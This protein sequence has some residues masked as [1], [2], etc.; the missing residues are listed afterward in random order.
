M[1][2]LLRNSPIEASGSIGLNIH[3]GKSK[4]LKCN[5]NI[6]NPITLGAETVEEEGTF[7]CL[8]SNIDEQGG[9]D[10]GVKSINTY[11]VNDLRNKQCSNF[12][13]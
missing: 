6:T 8:G 10:A 9:S 3:K 12:F 4:I 2:V 7:T 13:S 1:S 11:L 5:T